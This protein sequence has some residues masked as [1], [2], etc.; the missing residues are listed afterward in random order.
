MGGD[1]FTVIGVSHHH[2]AQPGLQVRDVGRQAQD[3]HDLAGHGDVEAVLPG[4]ALHP[5]AQAVHDIAQLA[6]IH[7]HAA[8]PGDLLYVDAQGVALLNVVVQ[9]G[10]AQVV[11]SADGVEVAG[12]MEVDILHGHHLGIAAAGG[13]ALDAEYGTQGGFPQS[14]Q[15]VFAQLPHGVSQ[16][17]RGGGLPLAGGGGVDGS[18]QDQLAVGTFALPQQAVIHLGLVVAVQFQVFPVHTGGLGDL[19]DGLHGAGLGDLNVGHDFHAAASV[20]LNLV[21]RYYF[22]VPEK[23]TT[24]PDE[25]EEPFQKKRAYIF[26]TLT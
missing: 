3:R 2:A 5:S 8:L 17:H 22:S 26:T 20:Y 16:T 10:S 14:H 23:Y 11:G 24:N 21:N 6:V 1:G 18:D 25:M 9:H 15:S 7:I 12:E 13:T 19:G 4:D